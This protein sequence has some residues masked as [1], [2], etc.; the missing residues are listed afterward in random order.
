MLR[1]AL[2]E[3]LRWL[4]SQEASRAR[5]VGA[6]RVRQVLVATEQMADEAHRAVLVAEKGPRRGW[7]DTWRSVDV[8]FF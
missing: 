3:R 4:K 6:V 8:R 7:V 2:Q 1:H 5:G